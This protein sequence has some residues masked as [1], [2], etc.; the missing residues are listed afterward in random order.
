VC[1][2]TKTLCVAYQRMFNIAVVSFVIDSVWKLLDTPSY[3]KNNRKVTIC[4][5]LSKKDLGYQDRLFINV[6][7]VSL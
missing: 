3:I 4:T 2:A 1:L 7:Y 6:M 5:G